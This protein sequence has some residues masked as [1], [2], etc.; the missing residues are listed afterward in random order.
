MERSLD[1]PLRNLFF[2]SADPGA[3]LL[4]V[5]HG[6][7]DRMESF[8]DFPDLLLGSRMHTLLLNAPDPYAVGT[9]WYDI[10]GRQEPGLKKSRRILEEIA[11]RLSS[12]S[13]GLP[14]VPKNRIVLSGF[15][16]GAVVSLYT[17]LRA[18]REF[19]GV[20]ALSGY[21]YGSTEEITEAGRRTPIFMAHG[22]FD[23]VL[24]FETSKKHALLIQ[25]AGVSV[26]FHEYPIDHSICLEEMQ[27]F[28]AFL[29][30]L[31]FF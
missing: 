30:A 31:F 7:G 10:D 26:S 5:M 6:L 25:N 9:K 3:P 12:H 13:D 14:H 15:S 22:I 16:Q 23:P 19:A 4:I 28:R 17:A 21:F 11:D 29:E 8:R 27:D 2:E 1:L 20:G 24:P 18:Q